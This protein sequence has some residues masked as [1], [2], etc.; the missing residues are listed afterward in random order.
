MIVIDSS[1][2]IEYFSGTELSKKFFNLIQ[3]TT[4]ILVPTIILNEVFK[5]LIYAVSEKEALFAIAQMEEGKVI[6]ITRDIALESAR[7]SKH[8][9]LPLADSIIYATT[10]KFN[11][12]LY[13]L[14]KHFKDLPNVNYFEK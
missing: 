13:T 14:D 6:D 10:M 12:T 2:W 9:R 11:A 3:N 8:L 5:K 4:D 7:Y 1:C